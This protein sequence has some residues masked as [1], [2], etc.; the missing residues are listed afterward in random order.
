MKNMAGKKRGNMKRDHMMWM[1]ALVFLLASVA[2]T[3]A[4][5][6][7]NCGIY[8]YASLPSP[9][10]VRLI[11]IVGNNS[12]EQAGNLSSYPYSVAC[13][14]TINL[15]ILDL[16]FGCSGAYVDVAQLNRLNNSHVSV[17]GMYQHSMCFNATPY[18][19]TFHHNVSSTGATP[20]DYECLFAVGDT[21]NSHAYSCDHPNA[22][23]NVNLKLNWSY[24]GCVDLDN[25]MTY[26]GKVV[27]DSDGYWIN[28]NISLCEKT[29]AYSDSGADGVI[30]INKSDITIDCNNS[31]F[32]GDTTGTGIIASSKNNTV[33]ESCA[34][35][36]Y[37]KGLYF[38]PAFGAS[39][40]DLTISNNTYCILFDQMNNSYI[41]NVTVFNCTYGVYLNYTNYTN[42]TNSSFFNNSYGVYLEGSTDNLLYYNNFTGSTTYHAYSDTAGND[43]NTTNGAKAAGY[44]AEGNFWDDVSSLD[45]IDV[46]IDGFGDAGTQHPYNN[47]NGGNVSININDWGPM[48]VASCDDND[49]DTF[50][51]SSSPPSCAV[52]LDCDD[53]NQTLLPPKD[54]LGVNTNITLCSGTYY[55]N[56]S[57]ANGII[58]PGVDNI[59][60]ICNNTVIIGNFTGIASDESAGYGAYIISK[61]N[62]T[63]ESCNF[64]KYTQ[65]INV[66]STS[67]NITL[68]NMNI[69][70]NRIGLYLS[71]GNSFVYVLDSH[72]TDNV[73]YGIFSYRPDDVIVYNSEFR[74][75]GT[76]IAL[77][78]THRANITNNKIYDGGSRGI[79]VFATSAKYSENNTIFNNTIND[80]NDAIYLGAYAYNTTVYNNTLSYND[81]GVYVDTGSADNLLY[82][83]NFTGSTT[84]HAYSETSSVQ[85]N[86][87]FW[88]G[89]AWVAHG[90]YWDDIL[91]ISIFDVD[92][93]GFGDGGTEY[94]YNSSFSSEVTVNV[95]DWGP[96]DAG[97]CT[98]NDNDGAYSTSSHFSCTGYRDCDDN[99]A[100]LLPPRDGLTISLNTTLCNGT[101]YINTSSVMLTAGADYLDVVCNNTVM[102]GNTVGAGFVVSG[103][104]NVTVEN[105]NF[106]NYSYGLWAISSATNMVFRNVNTSDNSYGVAYYS[107]VGYLLGGR[108]DGDNW[109]VYVNN[110]DYI[111][112]DNREFHGGS[113]AIAAP[114]ANVSVFTNNRIYDASSSG[115]LLWTTGGQTSNNTVI[116]NNTITNSGTGISLTV[117]V[118]NVSIYN[119]T[120]SDN[121]QGISIDSSPKDIL[122]YYNNFTD[123][124]QY[125]AYSET[126]SVYFNTSFWNGTAWVAHG[127]YWSGIELLNIF[128]TDFDGFGDWGPAYPYNST[129][130]GNVSINVTDWGPI[131]DRNFSDTTP[132]N[133]S[134]MIYGYNGTEITGSRSVFLNLS[135]AD[136]FGVTLCRWANDRESNLN[137]YPWENCTGVKPWILSDGEGNKTVYYQIRDK[138]WNNVTYND[139]IMYS[140]IQD[141][142]PP[143][144]PV[145]YDGLS[146]TDIDWWNSNDTLSAYWWN[147]TDDIATIYYRYRIRNDSDCYVAGCGWTDADTDTD[148][149]VTGL[150]LVEG[151]NYSFD[152]IAYTSSLINS[153]VASSNGTTIDLTDPTAPIIN[154]T[155]H[156]DQT[157]TYDNSTVKLNF[158]STDPLSNGVASGIEGYSYLLDSYPGTAPDDNLEDRQWETL[159]S[160]V[161]DGSGQLLRANSTIASPNT[162]AVFSQLEGNFTDGDEIRVRAAIAEI[163]SDY[164]DE[165]NLKVYLMT[166]PDGNDITVFDNEARAISNIVSTARD[167]RYSASMSSA[168][169]YEFS[170]EVNTTNLD[171]AND[172]YIVIAGVTGDTD[173]R[174]NHSIALSTT[175]FD[176]STKNYVCDNE[177]N[178][179][180]NTSTLDYAIEVKR[181]DAGNTWDVQYDNLRD[182]TY[183]FHAKA[184]DNAGNW[185]DTEHYMITIDTEGV[186]VDIISPFTGQVF[187]DPNVTVEVEVDDQANVTVFAVHEDG[188]TDQ[189]QWQVFSTT[190]T[191]YVDIENGTNR[192]YARAINPDNGVMTYSQDVYVRFGTDV[193]VGNRTLTIRYA[194]SSCSGH[195]CSVT[196]GSAVTVGM[197]TENDTASFGADNVS[198]DTGHHTIKLFATNPDGIPGSVEDDLDDDDFL[199]RVNPMFG[200]TR[201]VPYYVIR[202]EMRPVNIYFSGDRRVTSGV[203]NLVFKNVGTTPDGKTNVTVRII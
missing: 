168:S 139:S 193:D 84:Y 49:G 197:A 72:F 184:K 129:N 187:S 88:N 87:S 155:T 201:G 40:S 37:T 136:D 101:Y 4:Q 190:S 157:V 175:E 92:D 11:N 149:T 116:N 85:F 59:D 27:N 113:S 156:P 38:D 132:P 30:I 99:N 41:E 80:S 122:V 76:A 90:N 13:N 174:N 160:I 158:T 66:G 124:T 154:S 77:S 112:V 34:V 178:W 186:A 47:S 51:S 121:T 89:S 163:T 196:E 96:I 182:G 2:M 152:V 203:Y 7:L 52:Y 117:D 33:L 141:F 166:I 20:A 58:I 170:L 110:A 126:A 12:H 148:V 35:R 17:D 181:Q 104:T 23:Y 64:T 172:T 5:S 60:I 98:D 21:N 46:N 202:T 24:T 179:Q 199:D 1:L 200:Y 194:T 161:N 44:Q 147:A 103:R 81:Y 131:T 68:R 31:I 138:A 119:N 120:L 73:L 57:G 135:Y 185:G 107:D 123:S 151:V 53:N 169:I 65:A 130:R 189:S 6:N 93:D 15:P 19:I 159:Q 78:R 32:I 125:H 165:L 22:T 180:E 74:R 137:N 63:L 102:I 10:Y 100:T 83:N 173:N 28:R 118:Y 16:D 69:S 183:Y 94:P 191:F 67:E 79:A 25:F 145:V 18:Y 171:T 3:S 42:V 140:F 142:T 144:A 133:G 162:S 55:I 45:I 105:C 86:T 108:S 29:Y 192:I 177:N 9:D 195:L 36:N 8:P 56:D 198:S 188:S 134:I 54:N 114:N 111:T 26:Q 109:G 167:I 95:T 115:I 70:G 153:S 14:S 146:G 39:V 97:T 127:N 176:N 106:T 91:T 71:L 48:G 82:Y 61:D 164:D 43:F 75:D 128:D 62:V 150:T 50:Y 143:T